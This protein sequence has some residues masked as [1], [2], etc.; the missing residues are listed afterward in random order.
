MGYAVKI[1]GTG[2]IG[3]PAAASRKRGARTGGPSFESALDLGEAEKAAAAATASP[4]AT[5]SGLLALQEAPD[6][7]RGRSKGVQR[8]EDMLDQLEDLRRGLI[9][10]AIPVAKLQ[11]LAQNLQGRR[12]TAGDPRLNQILG[13]IEVR[14]A[15]ELAKLGYDV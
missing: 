3:T 11:R 14:V 6:A 10:G 15:V 12:D 5:V 13:E 9:L 4:L 1:N 2:R 8:A 7:T